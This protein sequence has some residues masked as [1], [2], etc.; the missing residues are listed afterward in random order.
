M[1][2]NFDL[3]TKRYTVKDITDILKEPYK[4]VGSTD[5]RHFTKARPILD[6]D[7][8]TFAFIASE[9][10]DKVQLLE[11][12]AAQIVMCDS[13]DNLAPDKCLIVVSNPKFSFARV[14]KV[15]FGTKKEPGIH[16]TAFIHPE[17]VIGERTCIGPFSY[18]GRCKIGSDT[19]I[20]GHCHIYDNVQLGNNVS[21]HA[22]TVLGADGFGYLKNETGDWE[23]FP[24]IGGI[25]IEDDVEIGSNT[26]I[27][28]GALGNTIIEKGAKIDNLVHIAHNVVVQRNASVVAHAMIAGSCVIG[29]DSWI[30]PCA[31]LREY[32]SV[33]EGS[34]LGLGAVATKNIPPGE[35][36]IGIPARAMQKPNKD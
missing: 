22:G 26:C 33:G 34:T 8:T 14:V 5:N 24:H 31:S 19:V 4:I 36:W 3:P 27:D 12:T 21:I 29:K 15:L 23:N 2:K 28:R 32:V 20:H 1:N 35:T 7:S 16:P 13:A 30:A 10:T 17:A 25:I 9:R 18:V 11:K 6:A